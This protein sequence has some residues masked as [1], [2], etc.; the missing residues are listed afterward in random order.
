MN[1]KR[2]HKIID[3][4]YATKLEDYFQN[5][6]KPYCIDIKFEYK[7]FGNNEGNIEMY[8]KNRKWKD[9]YF[10]VVFVIP[11]NECFKFFINDYEMDQ[12]KDQTMNILNNH[13][14]GKR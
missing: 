14:F 7:D 13:I 1:E 5:F 10:Q 4:Y 8:I 12:L 6:L 3:K 9:D 2:I 11:Y